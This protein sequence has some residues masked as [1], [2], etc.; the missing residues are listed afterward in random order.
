MGR[1]GALLATF[2][3]QGADTEVTLLDELLSPPKSRMSVH[4]RQEPLLNNDSDLA[5]CLKIDPSILRS[6]LG[7]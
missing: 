4:P 3:V 6:S 1:Q 7:H 2:S 5:T